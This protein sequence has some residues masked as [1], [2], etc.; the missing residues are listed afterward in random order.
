MRRDKSIKI[1][2]Q[3]YAQSNYTFF[4][5]MQINLSMSFLIYFFNQ[6]MFLHETV[7]LLHKSSSSLWNISLGS[8]LPQR[9]KTTALFHAPSPKMIEAL[10]AVSIY[11]WH[12]LGF[13]FRSYIVFTCKISALN[14]TLE[15][16]SST[17]PHR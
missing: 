11:E 5:Q 3:H 1:K 15:P 17:S 2:T 9:L 16:R 10:Y 12:G 13:V 4:L 7:I 14:Q 6:M 8:A